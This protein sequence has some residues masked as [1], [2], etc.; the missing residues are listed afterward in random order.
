[1]HPRNPLT[2]PALFRNLCA[3]LVLFSLQ[4]IP[5]QN[6][7]SKSQVLEDLN[8]LKA[9]LETTHYNLYAYTPKKEFVRNFNAVRASV[10]KDSLS[11]LEATSL[12]QRVIS[13]ADN[14]HTEIGFPGQSYI[15]YAYGG[16]SVFPL[17]LAFEEGRAL[18]RKNW[19]GND[20]IETGSEVLGINGV[21]MDEIL[22]QIYPQVSAERPYFKHAK[23]ELYSFPR[24][25]WQVFGPQDSFVVEIRSGGK[26]R[27]LQLSAVAA[28]DGYE[29]KRNEV[30]NARMALKFFGRSAY[31]NPGNLSGNLRQFQG[32]ID[33]AFVK[34]EERKSS[35]LIVDLR[36]NQGGDDPF[37]DYL[38]SYIAD[39]PFQWSSDFTL[40]SSALLKQDTRQNRDTTRAFW[41][42]VLEHKNGEVYQYAFE[43]YQPQPEQKR[44]T[45]SVYV[46][47]NRQSHSQ[48]AL[49]A[50]QIQDY[51]F[52]T[53]VGEETGEYPSLYASVFR[54]GLPH[55]GVSVQ[56]AK[57]RIVRVNGSTAEKG[58]IPDI[59]IRDHLLDEK[60]EILQGL[61]EKLG[62]DGP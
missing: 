12:F 39:R 36:N 40:K 47:V 42:S 57:G 35:H 7:F 5:A 25:Y 46:L 41:Q 44:F 3:V 55:T 14:G 29:A 58:V 59:Y 13:K 56:V 32:F 10:K 21:S 1:M 22:E 19:S 31:L 28:L 54:Y 16:G 61:L 15:E 45:G 30:L 17:E 18:V 50:A 49:T 52:G 53:I 2:T 27:K 33:S 20:T 4:E 8:F 6:R 9:S 26:A 34:I 38:V 60:D 62:E 24:F 23:I 51:G 11:L 43:D 37:S 48:S